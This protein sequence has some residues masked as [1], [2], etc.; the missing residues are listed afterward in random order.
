MKFSK[1][2]SGCLREGEVIMNLSQKLKNAREQ[3]NLSQQDV[4]DSLNISRQSVSK[5]ENGKACP[6]IDN[7]AILSE[8]YG[9]SLDCL[10]KDN[11]EIP[12]AN[13]INESTPKISDSESIRHASFHQDSFYIV[14]ISLLS[15]IVP[16]IGLFLNLGIVI[17]CVVKKQKLSS[18]V[19]LILVMCLI[20]NL[21]NAGIVVNDY[22]FKYGRATVKKVA[23]FDTHIIHNNETSNLSFL[24]TA[25]IPVL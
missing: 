23:L 17:F 1:I 4:A 19:W 5:W 24:T 13:F 12:D 6:D 8:L 15:C 11:Q 3:A 21:I 25:H 7:L 9:V 18:L 16:L 10:L 14:A 20:I 2:T 22:F